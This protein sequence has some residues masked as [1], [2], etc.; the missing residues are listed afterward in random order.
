MYWD[1]PHW[2]GGFANF[3]GHSF[4]STKT[5]HGHVT[6]RKCSF[7]VPEFAGKIYRKTL[8]FMLETIFPRFFLQIFPPKTFF[9]NPP[10]H[11]KK[12]PSAT[13]PPWWFDDVAN[14]YQH[15]PGLVNV[16][17]L[18]TGKIHHAIDGEIN[19]FYGKSSC[20]MWKF[21]INDP[22]SIIF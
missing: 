4:H 13:G 3:M 5:I 9:G 17:I 15:L 22:C 1:I 19:N 14:I 6:D 16:D 7:L 21:T 20:L 8:H 11:I 12:C 10:K 18:R 2:L